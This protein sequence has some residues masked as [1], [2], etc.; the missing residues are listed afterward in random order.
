MNNRIASIVCPNCGASSTN[1]NKC[2]FCGSVLVRFADKNVT[3]IQEKFGNKA[4]IIP[5]LDSALEE[6]LALQE[7]NPERIVI[8]RVFPSAED[9]NSPVNN[10]VWKSIKE[11]QNRW[12][13]S[14]IQYDLF[15]PYCKTALWTDSFEIISSKDSLYGLTTTKEP[16]DEI[17]LTLR[18][19]VVK[20]LPYQNKYGKGQTFELVYGDEYG[21]YNRP[22][23]SVFNEV[24]DPE[25]V[26]RAYKFKDGL[27][28]L[29]DLGQDVESAARIVTYFINEINRHGGDYRANIWSV[30]TCDVETKSYDKE[31]LI[32]DPDFGEIIERGKVSTYD[33]WL[34]EHKSF[35]EKIFGSILR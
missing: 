2:E 21:I 4:T 15:P 9:R 24:V 8:T 27:C 18:V 16:T 3:D 13:I 23:V 1:R 14:G 22:V 5:E 7:S 32:I 17:G 12:K 19:P 26:F 33:K 30:Y 11:M 34:S 25:G 28:F 6:N 20:V 35:W 10:S 29:L 31:N